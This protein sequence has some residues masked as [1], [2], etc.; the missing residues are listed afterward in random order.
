MEIIPAINCHRDDIGC[1]K[2]TLEVAF[3]FLKKDGWVHLDV[4]DGIFTFNK[5]WGDRKGWANMRVSFN[6]EVHLMVEH[7]ENYAQPWVAAG[8]KR[9]IVHVETIT[10]ESLKEILKFAGARA[11]VMI[12]SNPETPIE[13]LERYMD[14]VSAFQ[15]LAVNPGLAGQKFLPTVLDKIRFLRKNSPD[16]KIEVDGGINLETGKLAVVAG[17]DILVAASYIFGSDNPKKSY[18]ELVKI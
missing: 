6:T 8:A 15:V 16:A 12:S 7:P 4:T 18:Q 9:L 13:N 17:A 10:P 5:T 2:A 11:E 1:V 14:T 3:S